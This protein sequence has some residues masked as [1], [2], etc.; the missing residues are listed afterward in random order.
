MALFGP[1][2]VEKLK[3]K[4]DIKGLI[5]AMGYKNDQQ[6]REAA[7]EALVAI[8]AP[9]VDPLISALSNPTPLIRARAADTLGRIGE[10]TSDSNLRSRMVE[11]LLALI[12]RTSRFGVPQ[13]AID[14]LRRI[15][16][17]ERAVKPLLAGLKD[18]SQ[19]A[20]TNAAK[21]LAYVGSAAV[22]PLIRLL[23]DNKPWLQHKA[24]EALMAMGAS[25]A[26][27]MAAAL[28]HDNDSVRRNA[29][30]IL[31]GMADTLEEEKLRSLVVDA[32]IPALDDADDET[33]QSAA[34]A[35]GQIPDPRT[36]EALVV[37][38]EDEDK[39][40]LRQDGVKALI[41]LESQVTEAGLSKRAADAMF[42]IL[43]DVDL[44]RAQMWAEINATVSDLAPYGGSVASYLAFGDTGQ[45]AKPQLSQAVAKLWPARPFAALA[46]GL[47]GDESSIEPL[48]KYLE[49]LDPAVRLAAQKALDV[50]HAT[51]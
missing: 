16:S 51:G 49:D 12:T 8:G 22:E 25:A 21:A 50:L 4:G 33:A 34:R 37:A 28:Q 32:L 23:E 15:G 19:T 1:P 42:A 38:L 29:A 18:D 40:G 11:P 39:T 24:S 5:K 20:S 36:A 44:D 2:N 3:A 13:Q 47:F 26:E 43:E 41:K 45:Q 30:T 6:V 27:P 35:L 46:L 10:Q 7:A 31:E 14:A 48:T 17:V 9:A